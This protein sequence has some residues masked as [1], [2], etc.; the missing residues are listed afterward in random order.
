MAD[1]PPPGTPIELRLVDELLGLGRSSR[2]DGQLTQLSREVAE[3]SWPS[4]SRASP[5][6]GL[7]P[8]WWVTGWKVW[9]MPA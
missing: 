1:H 4:M 5:E 7:L 8:R 3:K 2:G 6:K 9:P